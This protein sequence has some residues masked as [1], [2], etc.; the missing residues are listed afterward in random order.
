MKILLLIGF[1]ILGKIILSHN[2]VL[3]YFLRDNKE[4]TEN[5]NISY[6]LTNFDYLII[7]LF[8][9]VT[10]ILM[11]GNYLYKKWELQRRVEFSFEKKVL[12]K[13]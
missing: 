8:I 3:N 13:K 6:G 11:T 7:K 9:I 4:I 10:I 1:I 2:V 12:M 5:T